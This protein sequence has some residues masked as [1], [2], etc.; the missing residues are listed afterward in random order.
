MSAPTSIAVTT[1]PTPYRH[2]ALFWRDLDDL[3]TRSVAF[4]EAGLDAGE[5]VMVAVTDRL[6]APLGAALGTQARWVEHLDLGALGRNPARIMPAWLD[7][8]ARNGDGDRALRGLGEPVHPGSHHSEL[9]EAQVHEALMNV[10]IDRHVPLSLLCTYDATGLDGAALAEA[11]RSHPAVMHG[12][13]PVVPSPAYAGP[14]HPWTLSGRA[15]P[16][17]PRPAEDLAFGAEG[18]G[19]VRRL[20]HRHAVAAGLDPARGDDLVLAVNELAANSLDHGDGGGTV[21]V[22]PEDG[23]LV[24]EVRDGGHLTDL[25]AGR[26]APATDQRRGRG[27]WL[28][29][30]LCDLVQVRTGSGGTVVRIRTWV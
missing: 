17:P 19:P 3:L 15:L 9:A 24:V 8:I 26:T 25:M 11:C 13:E 29:H 27:L 6:W 10:A 23:A 14:G 18:L 4:V 20:I 21:H 30:Q 1:C 12:T 16:P 28:V 2:H 7:F 22:W 5:P